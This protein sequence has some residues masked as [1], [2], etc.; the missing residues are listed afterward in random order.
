[1]TL[2]D[3]A[4][5]ERRLTHGD[6]DV[7]P[8]ALVDAGQQSSGRTVSDKKFISKF[9]AHIAVPIWPSFL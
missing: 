5:S 2:P 7:K 1:M 8:L 6:E 3:L 4:K 9:H